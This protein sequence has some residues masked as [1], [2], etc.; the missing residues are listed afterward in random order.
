[1]LKLGAASAKH[2][3]SALLRR[4]RRR[5]QQAGLAKAGRPLQDD[6]CAVAGARCV[7]SR[8][9]ALQFSITLQQ[10]GHRV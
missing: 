2:V 7:E 8:A 4:G 10:H 1:V 3:K 9:E 5:S 6:E